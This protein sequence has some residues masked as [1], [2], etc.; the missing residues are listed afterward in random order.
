MSASWREET[1]PEFSGDLFCR[2][3]N[4]I[5]AISPLTSSI[6]N[7]VQG[8]TKGLQTKASSSR[9]AAKAAANP[10]KGKRYVPPKKTALVK[11]ASMRQ[12]RFSFH[13]LGLRGSLTLHV[14]S[15]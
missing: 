1:Y 10:K 6:I 9:Q 8:K 7:M 12:A 5:I 13:I 4:A 3:L 2:L 15:H 11:Q 14:C